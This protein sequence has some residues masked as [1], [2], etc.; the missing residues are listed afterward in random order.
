MRAPTETVTTE[1]V[2][3]I[4]AVRAGYG[5]TTVLQDV[6]LQVAAGARVAII[7]SNGA[8]KSTLLRTISGLV[9]TRRGS[10]RYGSLRLDRLGPHRIVRAGVV[11]VPEGRRCFAKQT[12]LDNLRLGALTRDDPGQIASDLEELLEQLPVLA[13]KLRQPAGKLSGGQQQVL[14]IARG[15]MAAPSLLLVDE[16]SL[17]LSPLLVDEIARFLAALAARRH[18]GLLLV[19]QNVSVAIDL[20]TRTY[21]MRN[22]RIVGDHE[23]SDL[24]GNTDLLEHYLGGKMR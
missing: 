12:V 24:V 3:A 15:I 5:P 2:L 7:G 1:G 9:R 17:G 18:I 21:L 16:L 22:G 23:S 10:I 6:D 19:E 20:S 13:E 8:G 4:E 14:A 11:H